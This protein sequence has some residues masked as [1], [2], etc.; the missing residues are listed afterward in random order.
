MNKIRRNWSSTFDK[1]C[2]LESDASFFQSSTCIYLETWRIYPYVSSNYILKN[3]L[4]FI[5]FA[6]ISWNYRWQYI[7]YVIL[8]VT[9]LNKIWYLIITKSQAC[10]N[11]N[12]SIN[13]TTYNQM[14]LPSITHFIDWIWWSIWVTILITNVKA[15]GRMEVLVFRY[16]C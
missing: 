2:I 5:I 16:N 3:I 4:I 12:T 8:R 7:E 10:L 13:R 1:L 11:K 9:Y 14:F 6:I 15:I